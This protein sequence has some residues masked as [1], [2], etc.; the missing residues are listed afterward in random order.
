[1]ERPSTHQVT[2]FTSSA[3]PKQVFPVTYAYQQIAL[4]STAKEYFVF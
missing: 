2:L 3:R 1:M 4:L